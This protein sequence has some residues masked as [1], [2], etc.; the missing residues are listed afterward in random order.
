MVLL[1][2]ARERSSGVIGTRGIFIDPKLFSPCPGFAVSSGHVGLPSSGA[3]S[4]PLAIMGWGVGGAIPT[5]KFAR[6]TKSLVNLHGLL[7]GNRRNSTPLRT[8]SLD[9]DGLLVGTL[10]AIEEHKTQLGRTGSLRRL[11]NGRLCKTPCVAL[12]KSLS[13]ASNI[14]GT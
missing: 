12:V 13:L 7:S 11:G 5:C 8:L 2:I 10:S 4:N 14:L 6:T 9:A 3:I 1:L